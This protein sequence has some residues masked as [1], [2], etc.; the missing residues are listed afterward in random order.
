MAR[1]H[2]LTLIS[3]C[4]SAT[5][6]GAQKY[7]P[8]WRGSTV[9][10][11]GE[12]NASPIVAVGEVVNIAPYGEQKVHHLPWPMSPEVHKLYWCQGDFQT[13]A[14]VKGEF[15]LVSRRFLW[16]SAMPGCR[17]YP[18]SP[19]Q[20]RRMNTHV[21]FLREEGDFLRPTYDGGT[22]RFLSLFD[23][24]DSLQPIPAREQLGTLL[25]KPAANSDT[26]SDYAHYFPSVMDIACE[27]L[28]NAVC[29]EH[30]KAL[31]GLGDPALREVACGFLKGQFGTDC[32]S[33]R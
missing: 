10:F 20:L 11:Q 31:A 22:H 28:G 32:A 21:W 23:K 2:L 4:C 24:W 19:I 15:H 13:T 17:L 18:E 1:I 5:A 7:F 33:G 6:D 30:I 12:W 14:V 26:L 16:G 29:V 9:W 3:L 27:L 25:L 8:E